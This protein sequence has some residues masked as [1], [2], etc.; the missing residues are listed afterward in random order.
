MISIIWNVYTPRFQ[1]Q[2]N[3]LLIPPTLGGVENQINLHKAIFVSLVGMFTMVMKSTKSEAEQFQSWV[4]HEVL[5]SINRFGSYSI[6]K[7][8][9][10][11]MTIMTCTNMMDV[12]SV[13]WPILACMIIYRCSNTAS[14][15]IIIGENSKSIAKPLIHFS[16]CISD[17]RTIIISLKVYSR[18]NARVKISMFRKNSKGRTGQNCLQWMNHSLLNGWEW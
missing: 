15:L 5:P 12:T 8:Y 1:Q 9:D 13:I 6:E 18:K 3:A 11:F 2:I 4:C 7:K 16:C 14:P 10:I 17:K